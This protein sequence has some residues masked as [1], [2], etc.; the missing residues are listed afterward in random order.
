MNRVD[1]YLLGVL[2]HNN[3]CKYE[4]R[5]ERVIVSDPND[6]QEFIYWDNSEWYK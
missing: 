3:L 5:Q 2:H 4:Y 6:E 1:K